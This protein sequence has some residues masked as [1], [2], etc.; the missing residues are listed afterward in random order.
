MHW[1]Y[2]VNGRLQ[3]LRTTPKK[4]KFHF[5]SF[6]FDIFFSYVIYI[7]SLRDGVKEDISADWIFP[8][9]LK[10]PVSAVWTGEVRWG[11]PGQQVS[12]GGCEGL[13]VPHWA[14]SLMADPDITVSLSTAD[15]SGPW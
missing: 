10:T 6:D 15:L 2:N 14:Q 9:Y 7:F 4:G 12:G 3:H 5:S 1:K 8:G 13:E 11:G